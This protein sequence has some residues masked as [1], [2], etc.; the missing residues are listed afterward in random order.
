MLNSLRD[1][2]EVYFT[3]EEEKRTSYIKSTLNKL[4]EYIK[5]DLKDSQSKFL[6]E[7]SRT[8]NNVMSIGETVKD[9]IGMD[10]KLNTLEHSMAN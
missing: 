1:Y 8:T 7:N 6:K 5:R 4:Q 10:K 9:I 3:S 2:R